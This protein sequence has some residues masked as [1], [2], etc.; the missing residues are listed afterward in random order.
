M[1]GDLSAAPPAA[2]YRTLID[3]LWQDAEMAMMV[4]DAEQ[5][6]RHANPTAM[7]LFAAQGFSIG[8]RLTDM[9]DELTSDDGSVVYPLD[10]WPAVRALHGENLHREPVML[11]LGAGE[12]RRKVVSAQPIA[13]DDGTHGA[14]VV[15][16]DATD[17]WL[18]AEHSQAELT[19]LGQ[20][21]EG[22]SDYAIIML[23][24][25]G[26]IQSWSA[27][28]QLIQGYTS[29]QAL[30]MPY[31]TFFDDGDRAA[32]LPKKILMKAARTGKTQVEGKRV[33]RDG[34]VFW[35]HA[36]LT[37]I[38][39]EAG[40]LQ[41]F[42]KVTHDVS[43][44]RATERAAV[45]LNELLEERVA[46]R[47]VQLEQQ[48]ADLAAVN[49]ELEA[50]SYSVSHDLRAPLR[51]MNGFAR[52]MEQDLGDRMPPEAIHYL[53]KVTE[54]AQHM[55]NLIDAL[56]SFSRMQ[57]QSMRPVPIDMTEL[58]AECWMSLAWA[59]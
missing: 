18:I 56:L 11:R 55:G 20:L 4:V 41:G 45:E 7:E 13:L 16:H 27:A 8:C 15:W 33:R 50:F 10:Q 49:A 29:E 52:L 38:R 53:G 31:D 34:S 58:V 36:A 40:R 51:A 43:E 22:A 21:L 35:A 12:P 24:P 28:A 5:R 48:A 3:L 26:R 1:L 23:D 37:A 9:A 54:N 6:V 42:V 19:R 46:E 25:A 47:T 2:G 32:G 39:D 57:R 44:R 17:S 30:G 59:R 14:L